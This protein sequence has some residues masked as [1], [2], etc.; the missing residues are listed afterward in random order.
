MCTY[1]LTKILLVNLL[2][3][4]N[5]ECRMFLPLTTFSCEVVYIWPFWVCRVSMDTMTSLWGVNTAS[6]EILL[7]LLYFPPPNYYK[8]DFLIKI[9]THRL[10][11]GH[12]NLPF[13]WESYRDIVALVVS[14]VIKKRKL[15][16]LENKKILTCGFFVRHYFQIL[17]Q[18][19]IFIFQD[20]SHLNIS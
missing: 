10:I 6:V 11:N 12:L 19:E 14:D 7:S 3:N 9:G 15:L 16:Y 17:A 4:C 13:I 5:I 1:S 8:W 18:Y 2:V 20:T